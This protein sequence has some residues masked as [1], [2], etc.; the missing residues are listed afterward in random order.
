MAPVA[1]FPDTLLAQILY[2]TTYPLDIVK[3][4]R[5]VTQSADLPD[6]ERAAAVET[7][8]WDPSVQALAAG[9]P[10]LV[11]R[12]NDHIDWTEQ[13]GDAVLVQTDDVMDS[14]QRLRDQAAETAI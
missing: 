4:A 6:K 9:F 14:V 3:A 11:T 12:M 8:D 1:L 10:D 2:A 13:V 5:F 7:M